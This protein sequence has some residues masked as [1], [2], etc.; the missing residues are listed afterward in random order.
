M[1]LLG[2]GKA[3]VWAPHHRDRDPQPAVQLAGAGAGVYNATRQ[4]GAV[5]GSAAIAVLMDSPAR[6]RGLWRSSRRGGGQRAAAG[7]V[8]APFSDAMAAAMLLPAAVL[9]FGLVAVLFFERRATWPRARRR[10][11]GAA[12]PPSSAWRLTSD[13]ASSRGE[14]SGRA[15]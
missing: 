5:L 9:V 2:I 10:Q 6:G 11:Q 4:V 7:V 15:E 8:L 1:A 14:R 12:P 3:C 13:A